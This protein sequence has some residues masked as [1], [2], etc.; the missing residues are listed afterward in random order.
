VTPP[1][2][3]AFGFSLHDLEGVDLELPE[4]EWQMTRAERCTLATLLRA[5]R[6]DHAIEVGTAGGG[7]LA[8]LAAFAGRAYSIDVD[9]TCAERLGGRHDNVQFLTGPSSRVLPDL[10]R[11]LAAEGSGAGFVLLDGDHSAK[12]VAADIE[13]VLRCRPLAPLHLLIHDSFNPPCREGILAAPWRDCPFVHA[14]DVDFVPGTLH[15]DLRYHGQLWE[16]FAAALLLPDERKGALEVRQSHRLEYE[17]LRR[18]SIWS[19]RP[20][21]RIRARVDA[22]LARR[23]AREQPRGVK[24]TGNVKHD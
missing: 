6:P 14:V 22:S 9:P 20:W 21:S 18:S 8:V 24:G 4:E 19:P 17:A 11:R 1:A 2:R 12:G 5:L 13:A 7:S 10:L 3:S 23:Q 16:G 15:S